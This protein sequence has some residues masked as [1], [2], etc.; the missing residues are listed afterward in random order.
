V[1]KSGEVQC[2]RGECGEVSGETSMVRIQLMLSP[3]G[4]Q[5]VEVSMLK[6]SVV[7]MSSVGRESR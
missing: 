5:C 2:G 7:E 3:Y 6:S 4:S 1:L